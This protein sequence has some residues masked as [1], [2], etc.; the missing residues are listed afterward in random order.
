MIY[1]SDHSVPAALFSSHIVTSEGIKAPFSLIP[2]CAY[3]GNLSTLGTRTQIHSKPV[4]LAPQPSILQG[5]ICYKIRMDGVQAVPRTG[6][7][8]Q[9]L[10]DSE[11]ST[12]EANFELLIE[13]DH[14]SDMIED[15]DHPGTGMHADI[16][17]PTLSKLR[18]EAVGTFSLS[19]IKQMTASEKFLAKDD[20]DKGCSEVAFEDCQSERFLENVQEICKCI[21]WQI[22][23]VLETKVGFLCTRKLTMR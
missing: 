7:S 20:S 21:P 5:Q 8:L 18:M 3:Q 9:V 4:C 15:G 19:D 17:I 6:Y 22:S 11:P 10:L 2:F 23:S 16:Y 13:D 1:D 14:H 12:P